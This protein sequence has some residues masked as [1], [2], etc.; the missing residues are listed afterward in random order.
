[1][2]VE[3]NTYVSAYSEFPS[4]SGA[5]PQYQNPGQ[6]VWTNQRV[7]QQT[8]VQR[9]QQGGTQAHHGQDPSQQALDDAFYSSNLGSTMDEYRHGGQTGVG[10]LS[11][12]AQPQPSSIEE[13]PPL[14]RIGHGEIGQ[15]SRVN[16]MQNAA[17]GG[18]ASAS[19]FAPGK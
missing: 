17:S 11:S 6:A 8:P 4:L 15:D 2:L 19:G 14:G 13:F 18:F 12:N 3:I 5:Q 10:Q 1:M 9:P 16:L 7:N